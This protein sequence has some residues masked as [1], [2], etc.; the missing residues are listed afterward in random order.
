MLGIASVSKGCT[1]PATALPGKERLF[2]ITA[3]WEVN[4]FSKSSCQQE[5]Q[6]KEKKTYQFYLVNF[7]TTLSGQVVL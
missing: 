6:P 7:F 1:V 5:D 4:Y 3:V 2:F